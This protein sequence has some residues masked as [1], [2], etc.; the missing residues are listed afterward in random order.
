[1]GPAHSG[2]DGT[3][4]G[5]SRL[6]LNFGEETCD[7]KLGTSACP[8]ITEGWWRVLARVMSG[9]AI[10]NNQTSVRGFGRRICFMGRK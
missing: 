5:I 3:F 9:M 2:K 10:Y 4:P 6:P 8:R 1:V 7:E